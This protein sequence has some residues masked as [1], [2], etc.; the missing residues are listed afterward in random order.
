MKQL[1]TK[2]S[3]LGKIASFPQLYNTNMF[4]HLSPEHT[5]QADVWINKEKNEERGLEPSCRRKWF[6]LLLLCFEDENILRK[7]SI[8]TEL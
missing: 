2:H 8:Y 3:K 1:H 5:T 4:M 6:W 7:Q